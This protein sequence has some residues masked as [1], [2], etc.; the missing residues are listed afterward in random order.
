MGVGV[1]PAPPSRPEFS[2]AFILRR[3]RSQ[4]LAFSLYMNPWMEN[5]G[6][7]RI[8]RRKHRERQM[9]RFN[10]SSQMTL[11][12]QSQCPPGGVLPLLAVFWAPTSSSKRQD[13]THWSAGR[14]QCRETDHSVSSAGQWS[15]SR[16]QPVLGVHTAL[17]LWFASCNFLKR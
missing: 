13:E 3:C 4:M 17:L 7:K 1:G 8:R 6:T 9:G 5:S 11:Q 10:A 2:K 14:Q 15:L 12:F 16:G